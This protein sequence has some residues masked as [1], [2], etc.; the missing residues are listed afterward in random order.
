MEYK[1][2]FI[3]LTETWLDEDKQD[4][5]YLENYTSINKFREGRKGGGVSLQFLPNIPYIKMN[6]LAHFDGEMESIFIEMDKSVNNA[7]SN[8]IIGVIYRMPNACVEVFADRLTDIM[9]VIEKEHKL[10]HIM[11]DLNID[12]L[13][14][15]DHKSTGA[16]FDVLYSYNV[17]P[18]ITKPTRVPE[19]TATLI[20]HIWTNNFDV[21]TNRI[22]GILCT[23]TTDHYAIFHIAGNISHDDIVKDLPIL[24]RDIGQKTIKKFIDEMKI[25]SLQSVL[26][27]NKTHLSYSKFHEIVSSKYNVCFH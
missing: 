2:A 11:G 23:S 4:F 24:R 5:F 8:I 14:S 15:D 27:E 3:G 6:D 7:N 22:Q 18:L 16:L 1:F 17:S 10:C 12:F 25:I 26:D 21:D 13:K 19:K 20:D 9:N